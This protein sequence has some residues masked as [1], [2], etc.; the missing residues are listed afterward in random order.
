MASAGSRESKHSD[1][2]YSDAG[3]LRMGCES[4]DETGHSG[5]E[6][7]GHLLSDWSATGIS[8]G[9]GNIIRD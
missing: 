2:V 4:G 9:N 5:M 3:E 6:H 1:D 8:F 7:L